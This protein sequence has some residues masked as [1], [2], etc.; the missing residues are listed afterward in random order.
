MENPT[1]GSGTNRPILFQYLNNLKNNLKKVKLASDKDTEF[2]EYKIKNDC[3]L[4]E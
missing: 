3:Y 4:I 2:N 1:G